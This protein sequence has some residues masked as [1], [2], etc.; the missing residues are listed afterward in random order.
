MTEDVVGL[1]FAGLD[2][3]DEGGAVEVG[4]VSFT[5]VV[6]VARRDVAEDDLTAART[7]GLN[8]AS[9]RLRGENVKMSGTC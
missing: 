5:E 6:L 8:S 9:M 3:E 4:R 2:E 1:V 7:A